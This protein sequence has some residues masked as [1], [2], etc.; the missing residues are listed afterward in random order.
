MYI[1]PVPRR[2]PPSP[3]RSCGAGIEADARGGGRDA[4]QLE[5]PPVLVPIAHMHLAPAPP[6][7]DKEERDEGD[8]EEGEEGAYEGR[9]EFAV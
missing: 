8:E 7:E 6:T 3:F 4:R 2:F 1:R 9:E 5:P